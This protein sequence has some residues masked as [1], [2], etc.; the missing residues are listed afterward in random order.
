M[1]LEANPRMC[2]RYNDGSPN[3]PR[4]QVQHSLWSLRALPMNGPVEWTLDEKF[5]RVA[6]AGFEGVECWLTDDDEQEHTD[7]LDRYGLR[8]TLGHHPHTLDDVCKTVDRAVRLNADF[9]FAQ[10][11]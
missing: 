3:P 11:L 2:D 5:S 4:L 8:L 6:A 1:L 7:T 10:P 9:I